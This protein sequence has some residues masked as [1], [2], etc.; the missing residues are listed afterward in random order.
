MLVALAAAYGQDGMLVVDR[1]LPKSNW[2]DAAGVASRANVR[3]T[4]Y[5][6]GFV[7]DDFVIGQAGER[8]I[9][10]T[11]RV[12]TVPGSN[13]LDPAALGDVYQDIRLYVGADGEDLTPIASGR[14]SRGSNQ[15]EGADVVIGEA[16]DAPLYENFGSH[17]KIYQVEFRNLNLR[18]EG[19]QRYRFGAWALGRAVDEKGK[20]YPWFTHASNASLGAAPADGSDGKMLLLEAAGQYAREYDANGDTWNKSSDLN[21]Q[22]YAQRDLSGDVAMTGD[23][24]RLANRDID[25]ATIRLHGAAPLE[26]IADNNGVAVRFASGTM[27]EGGCLSA[28]TFTGQAIRACAGR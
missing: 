16:R 7:G 28:R 26:A 8:W 15:V 25:P 4:L 9:V 5:D 22:I 24:V 2:N 19:G 13:V 17:L 11:I 23:T 27:R 12:W 3:W 20:R 21:V 1:G 18:V 6:Q 10:H 14:L